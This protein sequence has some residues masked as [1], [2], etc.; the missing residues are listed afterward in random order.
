MINLFNYAIT[1]TK[2]EEK[3]RGMDGL[4]FASLTNLTE[5]RIN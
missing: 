2:K 5:L 1:E 3:M 4:S